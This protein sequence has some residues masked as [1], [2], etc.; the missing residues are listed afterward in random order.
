MVSKCNFSF[1][2]LNPF[3][4][5]L[6]HAFSVESTR[7]KDAYI[8]QDYARPVQQERRTRR[9]LIKAMFKANFSCEHRLTVITTCLYWVL[10]RIYKLKMAARCTT[11]VVFEP[12][13]TEA[14]LLEERWR[15][16]RDDLLGLIV[17][18]Q[19]PS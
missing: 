15:I 4:G 6:L 17:A 2:A 11:F 19:V 7:L 9:V 12:W 8:T 10:I 5:R 13:L 18:P 14:A 16:D 1:T 3:Q